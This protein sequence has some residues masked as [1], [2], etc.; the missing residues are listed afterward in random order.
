MHSS[1]PSRHS[2]NSTPETAGSS[3]S[4][5][6]KSIGELRDAVLV[7]VG[8]TYL[9]GYLLWSFV[10]WQRGLGFISIIDYQ[11]LSAGIIPFV[12]IFLVVTL[13]MHAVDNI[14]LQVFLALLGVICLIL[15]IS[16]VVYK[17][18][19]DVHGLY[20][21]DD[22][23]FFLICG[24]MLALYVVISAVFIDIKN[25][26]RKSHMNRR[27]IAD[28]SGRLIVDNFLY[29]SFMSIY[30]VFA[31]V[32]LALASW[33]VFSK[34]PIAFGG[35]TSRCATLD[36]AQDKYSYETL[37]AIVGRSIQPNEFAQPVESDHL[38][39]PFISDKHV[40]VKSKDT[41]Y[42]LDRTGVKSITWH[43]CS[44]M[45]PSPCD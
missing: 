38:C 35:P 34:L 10:A 17:A 31:L 24:M 6:V 28:V 20:E 16:H 32:I 44:S 25:R 12:L 3:W 11:Y 29:Y 41:V 45:Q 7:G 36:L 27:K 15:W 9:L 19:K 14:E 42:E 39:I 1:P 22:I 21:A 2:G 4:S 26:R 40:F 37:T 43:N 8:F 30:S 23:D 5:L 18:S 13:M 33:I